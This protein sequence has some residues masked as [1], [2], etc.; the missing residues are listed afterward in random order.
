MTDA[1][2]LD[3]ALEELR[4]VYRDAVSLGSPTPNAFATLSWILSDETRLPI[5][6]RADAV[7]RWMAT[8]ELDRWRSPIRASQS[9][10]NTMISYDSR[11]S[12]ASKLLAAASRFVDAAGQASG[13]A[14]V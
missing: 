6:E 2:E 9:G 11:R 8:P 13:D 4:R 10:E 7:R 3:G 5:R 1:P 14:D 12:V